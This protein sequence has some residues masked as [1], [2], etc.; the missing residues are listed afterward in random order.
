MWKQPLIAFLCGL[1]LT[2]CQFA[3]NASEGGMELTLWHGINPPPNRD[4]FNELVNEFNAEHDFRIKPLYVGQPDQQL[5][6]ILTSVVGGVP[7]DILWFGPMLTGQLVELD[8]IRPI[9]DWLRNSPVGDRLDP[10]LLGG[11][12]LEGEIW[13]IPMA[14]N[15]IG[16]FYRP[17]LFAEAGIETLPQTWD[18]LREVAR[19]LTAD[20]DD[21]GTPDRYGM[22]LP[23]GKGE[24]TVFTW[25]PFLYGTGGEL[26]EGN[27]PDLRSPEAIAAL[28]FWQSLIEDGSVML[29]QPERGY[30]LTDYLDGRVAMQLTGPWTLGQL[31]ALDI[32]YDAMAIPEKTQ[33]ATVVGGEHLF[34]MKTDPKRERAALEFLEFVLSDRFQTRWALGTGYL[35]ATLSARSQPEYQD[36]LSDRP[37]LN[38]FIEQ[39]AGAQSR[40]IL[41]NYARLSDSLGRAIEQTLLGGEP[42]AALED[43]QERLDRIWPRS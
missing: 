17:S 4:V 38:V 34:V 18:E 13:S 29:S 15:N 1:L 27:A 31:S 40:P 8:A 30:E 6:K 28:E 11:M 26:I 23:L 21:D 24:W 19:Q 39:M 22:L 5:P 33:A 20:L 37:V 16:L 25:L 36:Y 12:T 9:G 41:P 43:A 7:P 2:A 35:P 3:P 10:S 14:T 42:Q 32:D